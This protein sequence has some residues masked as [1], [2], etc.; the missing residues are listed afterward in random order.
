M[1]DEDVSTLKFPTEFEKTPTLL[2]IEVAHLLQ[3]RK[4][5]N[6]TAAEQGEGNEV[7]LGDVFLKTLAYCKRFSRYKNME[8]VASIRENLSERPLHKFEIAQLANLCPESSEEA[9]ALKR[10]FIKFFKH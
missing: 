8:T 6:D 9:K 4:L 3:Q 5:Q 2:N 7:E 10:G 1:E